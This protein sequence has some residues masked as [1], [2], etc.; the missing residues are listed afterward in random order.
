MDSD[1]GTFSFLPRKDFAKRAVYCQAYYRKTCFVCEI[2]VWITEERQMRTKMK[3][4][5]LENSAEERP[6]ESKE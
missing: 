5:G 3:G 2:W 1:N 6:S 4:R